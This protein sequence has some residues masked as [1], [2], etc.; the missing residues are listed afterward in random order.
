MPYKEKLVKDYDEVVESTKSFNVGLREHPRLYERLS[1]FKAWYY[2]PEIDAVGPS[3]FIGY[4]N[5]CADFYWAHTGALGKATLP[6]S[7][8]LDGRETEP[9]LE[10]WFVVT[11]PKTPEH[12]FVSE[13]TE[14][15]LDR[16]NKKPNSKVR[17]C[18]PIDFRITAAQDRIGERKM[19]RL[20]KEAFDRASKLS[21]SEQDR[22]ARVLLEEM[23][24]DRRW[25]E[26]FATP[27]SEAFLERMG[28]E[29][30]AEHDA[31]I[32]RPL[33]VED[34]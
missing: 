32:T 15:L 7:K 6:R 3:K 9:V 34:L 22:I 29:T 30:W 19:T 17:Y 25:D 11:D 13:M 28:D 20:L 24:S 4:G 10:E 8:Q 1:G 27:E 5:M 31:G 26:L 16:W 12:K 2:I 23:E 33:K 21:E 18:V 14:E